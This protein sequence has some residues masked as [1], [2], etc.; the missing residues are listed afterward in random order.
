[1]SAPRDAQAKDSWR[2]RPADL[3]DT[4]GLQALEANPLVYRYLCDGV[5]PD[6]EFIARAVAHSVANAAE[7]GLGV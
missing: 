5:P 4:D 1:M 2:L 3:S 7:T 6:K